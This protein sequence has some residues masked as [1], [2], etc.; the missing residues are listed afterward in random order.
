MLLFL[1]HKEAGFV[2]AW[3]LVDSG[4]DSGIAPIAGGEAITDINDTT[5]DIAEEEKT[6]DDNDSNKQK[7]DWE[8]S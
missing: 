6:N 7:E 5:S 1:I 3:S 8:Q 2:F 4:I